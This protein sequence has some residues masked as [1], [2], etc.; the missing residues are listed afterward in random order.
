M[1]L[2]ASTFHVRFVLN[3]KKSAI[4]MAKTIYS[5]RGDMDKFALAQKEGD[6]KL[7]FCQGELVS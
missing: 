6:A 2:Q 3:N 1:D 5:C 7:L 4:K